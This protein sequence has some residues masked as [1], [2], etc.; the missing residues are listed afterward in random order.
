M[1]LVERN[2]IPF[3]VV[4]GFNRSNAERYRFDRDE[5]DDW[6]IG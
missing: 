3:L 5:I 4:E 2:A 1:G 6:V